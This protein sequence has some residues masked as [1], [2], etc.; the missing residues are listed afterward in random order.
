MS[1]IGNLPIPIPEGVTVQKEGQSLIVKGSKGT[2]K[3]EINSQVVVEILEQQVIVK[4]KNEVKD[5]RAMHGTTRSLINNMTV[6]VRDGWSKKLELVGV[7]YRAQVQG[8]TLVMSV[9]FSH[10]VKV[11]AADDI[12]FEVTDNTKIKISGIDKHL[13]GLVAA[14]IRNI[15]PPEPY[16]GKGVRYEGEY[17]RRKPGKAGKVGTGAVGK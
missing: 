17:I 5:A 12:Q 8:Q 9:G 11:Q 15:R 6:G 2:L 4:R 1:R 7:G 10:P 13:V 14:K 3:M 16:K